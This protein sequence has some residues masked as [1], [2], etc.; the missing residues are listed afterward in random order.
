MNSGDIPRIV[1]IRPHTCIA[2]AANTDPQ[3]LMGMLAWA[4]AIGIAWSC[5]NLRI[6]DCFPDRIYEITH[7]TG[8]L[9]G[10]WKP[11]EH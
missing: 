1:R 9:T 5:L 2:I 11:G 10:Q 3:N 4:I 6:W 8:G 7:H